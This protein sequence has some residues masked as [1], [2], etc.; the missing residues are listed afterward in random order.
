MGRRWTRSSRVYLVA[1]LAMALGAALVVHSYTSRLARAA[2]AVGDERPVVVAAE[3]IS[4]GTALRPAQ[5][6]VLRIPES[7]APPASFSRPSDVAGRVALVDLS[8]GEAVTDTRLARVRAGPVASLVPPGL[9]AFAVPTTLPLGSVA[10]GDRVDVLATFGTGRPHTE[11]VVQGVEV[12]FILG[13]APGSGTSL[14]D[15]AA[16]DAAGAGATPSSM[17]ILVVSPTQQ[18][19]LAFAR[20]FANLEV[21]IQPAPSP[22]T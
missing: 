3:R 12:L 6:A 11:T 16:F 4:R 19:R 17:L 21:T 14:L 9:R 7:F 22:S 5:L 20:S 18:E 15:D 8:A 1:S 2:A 10:V 13:D